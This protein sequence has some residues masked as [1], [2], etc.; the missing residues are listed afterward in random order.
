MP[1]DSAPYR[2]IFRRFGL[3]RQQPEFADALQR[4]A[5][6]AMFL[7]RR[8]LTPALRATSTMLS[9]SSPPLSER[10]LLLTPWDGAISSCR[11]VTR[12]L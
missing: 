8:W 6:S 4:L 2:G 5:L 7:G 10:K 12:S 9:R 1:D 11:N 3:E